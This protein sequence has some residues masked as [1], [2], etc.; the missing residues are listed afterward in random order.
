MWQLQFQTTELQVSLC[1][2][3]WWWGLKWEV[4]GGS[5]LRLGLRA[6]GQMLLG[7]GVVSR[8]LASLAQ[9][10][11]DRRLRVIALWRVSAPGT[12]WDV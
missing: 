3:G 11:E 8:T 4:G 1:T 7:G 5:A 9:V 2:K 6:R 10:L 12:G